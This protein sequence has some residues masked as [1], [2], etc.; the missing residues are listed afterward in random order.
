[1]YRSGTIQITLLLLLLL[2][3]GVFA[4]QET[5]DKTAVVV[6]DKIILASELASQMQLVAFQTNRRPTTEDEVQKFKTEILEQMISDQ[7]FLAEARKDTTISIR[8]E[9]I[10]RALE[11]Q[12]AR[13]AANVGSEEDF[14]AA[15]A[16]EGMTLRDLEKRYRGEIENQLLKQ[17]YIQQKLHTV[18][19]SRREV[20]KFY[21]EFKDSIPKQPETIKLAHLLLEIKPSPEVEDSVRELA[22][23]LRQRILDGADFATLSAQNSSLGAGANGGDLGYIARDDVVPE[24]ARAAFQ[25]DVGDISGVIRSQFGYHVIK[26]EGKRD[27]RL[28]LRHLLLA[29]PP[30]AEDSGVV[31]YLADSLLKEARG[32]TDFAEMAKTYSSDDDTR[33]AG[34]ELGWFLVQQMPS[35]FVTAVSGWKTPGEYRGPVMSKFGVH[36]LKLLDHQPE[37]TLS[38]DDDFDRIKDLARQDK[39]GREVDKWIEELKKRTYIDYRMDI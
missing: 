2:V 38:L 27:D 16:Q 19:V 22:A 26:C 1:M 28:R 35:E 25:L 32:G 5:V 17:R 12:I 33:G 18:S 13:V 8:R 37:K 39:T 14:L 23:S 21:S 9:E 3:G 4:Q 20:E 10:E 30:S 36:L 7:L 11:E 34:G 29:V 24:F 6:G 31:L 15:L